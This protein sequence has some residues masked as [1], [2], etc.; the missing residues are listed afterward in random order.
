M[1][2]KDLVADR[3]KLT[4]EAIERIISD[5]IR[6]DPERFEVV[7]TPRGT[8]LGN[9]QKVLVILVALLGWKYVI[10][11][12]HE[13]DARPTTL[14]AL[15]GIPGG[16]LR[17]ILKKL[18]DA[19]L[20]AVIGG[21]YSVR[22]ANLEAIGSIVKGEQP[23]TARKRTKK[24]SRSTASE[25]HHSDGEAESEGTR[26]SRRSAGTP[27]RGSLRRLLESGFFNEPRTLAQVVARLHEMAVITK[28][29]SLSGPIA[30]LVRE[31]SLHRKKMKENSKEVWSYRAA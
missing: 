4:E 10:D 7:L 25:R 23:V 8:G 12:E 27:A 17:P 3:S 26:K 5:Y 1:A 2:L 30:E 24:M 20:L 14:E 31:G 21:N 18:K 29:T 28:A 22:P 9:D 11:Y 15:T 19:H 13:I 16:T 6:Y